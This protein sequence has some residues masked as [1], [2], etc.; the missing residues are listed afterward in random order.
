M[1]RARVNHSAPAIQVSQTRRCMVAWGFSS[2]TAMW[3]PALAGGSS[4]SVI[5]PHLPSIAWLEANNMISAAS[6][7]SFSML[8]DP[9]RAAG[10]LRCALNR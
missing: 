5:E 9:D 3:L 7:S 8:H 4:Y 1:N 2:Q 6:L 10:Q